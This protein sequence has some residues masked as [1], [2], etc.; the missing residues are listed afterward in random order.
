MNIKHIT[1]TLLAAMTLDAAAATTNMIDIAGHPV[2]VVAGGLYDRYR[3]NP[4][5]SVIQAEAPDVD[6]SWFRTLSKTKVDIGFD[7]WSPNFY[8]RN[9]RITAIFTADIDR[10]R[11]WQ[12]SGAWSATTC[13]NG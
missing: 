7:T 11:N 5:L 13:R 9:T 4:P 2:P 12:G 8:Y 10:L 6:L 1:A 3:S